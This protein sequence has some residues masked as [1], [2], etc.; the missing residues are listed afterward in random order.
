MLRKLLVA[1][2]TMLALP[3]GAFAADESSGTGYT[4]KTTEIMLGIIFILMI[5]MVLIGV[6]ESRGKH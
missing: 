3:A 6:L 5:G 2:V 1:L 4:D